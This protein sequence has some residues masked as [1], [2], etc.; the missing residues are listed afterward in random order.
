MKV[1]IDDPVE[2]WSL[3]F[4]SNHRERPAHSRQE[5]RHIADA[6]HTADAALRD[7]I[8]DGAP[9]RRGDRAW[10]HIAA[11]AYTQSR[12]SDT[13]A[14]T[15]TTQPTCHLDEDVIQTWLNAPWVPTDDDAATMAEVTGLTDTFGPDYPPDPASVDI[16]V[17]QAQDMGLLG[18]PEH[19]ISLWRQFGDGTLPPLTFQVS[20]RSP[21][22]FRI[23][24]GP[25]GAEQLLD[26]AGSAA[27]VIVG[28]LRGVAQTVN[29][30]L[31]RTADPDTNPQQ[32]ADRTTDPPPRLDPRVDGHTVG[33]RG[34]AFPPLRVT[35]TG[36]TN[37]ARASD[38]G[39]LPQSRRSR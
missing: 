24:A 26:P 10:C 31:A 5:W 29:D 38:A 34:R 9:H 13:V 36:D 16:L 37:P 23:S 15:T 32:K 1:H 14:P 4:H 27:D 2:R 28:V 33:R 21:D 8:G 35:S 39:T 11:T 20:V 30:L 3:I 22:G 25:I 19:R 12:D 18:L 7:T 17:N 6:I